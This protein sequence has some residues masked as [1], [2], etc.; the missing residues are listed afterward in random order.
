M[1]HITDTTVAAL[2]TPVNILVQV[3]AALTGTITVADGRGT[4]A[5]ITNPTVGN[6]FRY[7]GLQGAVTATA[8]TTCDV[9]VSNLS[10]QN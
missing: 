6:I 5:V 8:S 9:T 10:R 2:G 1:I 4:Q 7:Y 3:N